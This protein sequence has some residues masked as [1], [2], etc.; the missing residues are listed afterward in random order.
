[1]L[2]FFRVRKQLSAL[3]GILDAMEERLHEHQV[4][5]EVMGEALTRKDDEML[6]FVHRLHE[7]MGGD[8]KLMCEGDALAR[9]RVLRSQ[10]DQYTAIMD[11]VNGRYC[12]DIALRKR[13][14]CSLGCAQFDADTITKRAIQLAGE[15]SKNGELT[16]EL[17][18]KEQEISDLNNELDD[19][20]ERTF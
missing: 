14:A 19:I 16:R 15:L 17:G 5:I 11:A 10:S 6:A 4:Q 3:N 2:N 13:L 8:Q 12:A 20:V 18:E 9:L 1:M 7:T